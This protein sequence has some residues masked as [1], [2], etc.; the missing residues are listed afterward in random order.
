M[1]AIDPV[2]PHGD[3]APMPSVAAALAGAAQQGNLIPDGSPEQPM[4]PAI[5]I[6]CTALPKVP[7]VP[8]DPAVPQNVPALP[9]VAADPQL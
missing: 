8:A 5:A 7:A 6:C 4:P 2:Q 1:V 9:N 3:T